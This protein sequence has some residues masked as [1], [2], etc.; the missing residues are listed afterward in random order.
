MQL[1]LANEAVRIFTR[2]GHDWT[3]RF[4][5]VADE[6]WHI[7]A[8]S[9]IIDGEIVVPAADGTTNFPSCRTNCAASPTRS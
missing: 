6:A 4:K 2:R 9:A 5:K 3:K 1:L 8:G 7:S